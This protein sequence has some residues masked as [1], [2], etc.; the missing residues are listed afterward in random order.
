MKQNVVER[1]N[2]QKQQSPA[3]RPNRPP[4]KTVVSIPEATK[5]EKIIANFSSSKSKPTHVLMQ[6]LMLSMPKQF[7]GFSHELNVLQE[8]IA[9]HIHETNQTTSTLERVHD[10][11]ESMLVEQRTTNILMTQLIALQES[12]LDVNHTEILAKAEEHRS[13][14]YA[15]VSNGE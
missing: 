4:A 10:R 7:K 2:K 5:Q 8:L 11:L 1:L 12:V 14:A 3:K 15:R 6:D 13:E 9:T